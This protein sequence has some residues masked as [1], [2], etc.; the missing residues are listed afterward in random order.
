MN[1][2]APEHR[3]KQRLVEGLVVLLRSNGNVS[4]LRKM[5]GSL[6]L[7]E[8][9]Q[10]N[11]DVLAGL[12]VKFLGCLAPIVGEGQEV[13]AVRRLELAVCLFAKQLFTK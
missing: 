10:L 9:H 4:E 1:P 13:P 6:S 2:F 5:L 7:S 11:E 8:L 12:D 3:A